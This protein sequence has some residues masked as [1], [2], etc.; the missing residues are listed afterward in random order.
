MG[1]GGDGGDEGESYK[2]TA[3]N[4]KSTAN[5]LLAFGSGNN[6]PNYK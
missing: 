5:S 4:Q 6:L 1:D 2:K 3:N